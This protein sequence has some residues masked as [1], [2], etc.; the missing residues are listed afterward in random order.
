MNLERFSIK[1][2]VVIK[3]LANISGYITEP[4]LYT[5]FTLCALIYTF[6]RN[7]IGTYLNDKMRYTCGTAVLHVA[8]LK[9]THRKSK[10]TKCEGT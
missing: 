7:A 6:C 4:L 1:Y 10:Q 8:L 9:T 5:R 3:L 2:N